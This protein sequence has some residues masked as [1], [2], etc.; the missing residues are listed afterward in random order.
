MLLVRVKSKEKLK[1]GNNIT[2][3]NTGNYPVV[4]GV[5]APKEIIILREELW[6]KM[7]EE[8]RR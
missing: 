4:L 1:I 7:K 8:Q 2:V 6:K 3:V 5:E